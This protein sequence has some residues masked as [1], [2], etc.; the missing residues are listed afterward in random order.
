V[1]FTSSSEV[2]RSLTVHFKENIDGESAQSRATRHIEYVVWGGAGMLLIPVII[3]SIVSAMKA[4]VES[5]VV[6]IDPGV[7]TQ[8]EAFASSVKSPPT[9][10]RKA[11]EIVAI[12]RHTWLTISVEHQKE[13]EQDL[14]ATSPPHLMMGLRPF[15][16]S[17][18]ELAGALTELEGHIHC[19]VRPADYIL[20]LRRSQESD[21]LAVAFD[22]ANKVNL[23]VK[24]IL[25]SDDRMDGRR[26]IFMFFFKVAEVSSVI[27]RHHSY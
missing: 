4:W 17:S 6:N 9:T 21:R 19:F 26:Q 18:S 23:L 10:S 11:Q 22:I 5:P 16:E 12:I 8:I 24:E 1:A 2:F 14:E 7:L 20:Y 3:H 15:L 25:L 13:E 27:S